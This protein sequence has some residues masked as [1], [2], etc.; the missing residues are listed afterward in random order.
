MPPPPLSPPPPCSD[1]PPKQREIVPVRLPP[2][3]VE[4]LAGLRKELASITAKM[5]NAASE[6]DRQLCSLQQ[7]GLLA[8]LYRTT[9]IG[10]VEAVTAHILAMILPDPRAVPA[11]WASASAAGAAGRG[12]GRGR[13][14]AA[15][16]SAGA[17]RK[18]GAGV[19]YTSDDEDN[20]AKDSASSD[21]DSNDEINSGAVR[22][23]PARRGNVIESDSDDGD[24]SGSVEG[25]G[26]IIEAPAATAAPSAA[27]PAASAG[28]PAAAATDAAAVPGAAARPMYTL[29]SGRSFPRVRKLLVF[30]H[31]SE[32]LEHLQTALARHDP[33]IKTV[34]CVWGASRA[35]DN[36]EL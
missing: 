14:G 12:R 6:T 32:V 17:K 33:P 19:Q 24:D 1:L 13:G 2:G 36:D 22:K 10:K 20:G 23:P 25:G 28:A 30:A 11:R 16:A 21:S 7:R 3:A 9:G 31:H 4:R 26:F 5:R 34:R 18:R 35:A 29:P 27:T 8:Q 15:G